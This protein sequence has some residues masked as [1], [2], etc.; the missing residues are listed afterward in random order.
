MLALRVRKF[1]MSIK[2]HTGGRTRESVG[3]E[4]LLEGGIFYGILC[5]RHFSGMVGSL[6]S[7]QFW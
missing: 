2:G 6:F 7:L 1:D 5:S 4:H 3:V